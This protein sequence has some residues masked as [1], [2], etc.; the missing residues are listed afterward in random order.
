LKPTV[1]IQ[2]NDKQLVG[3]RV[4]VH[5]F[6][7]NSKSADR[8]D[9]RIM[10]QEEQPCFQAREG[11]AF[12]RGGTRRVW[13]NDDLQSFTPLRFLPPK[14]MEYRG[15]ALVVDPDVFAVGDAW[16][17]LDRDMNGKAIMAVARPGH[18][19]RPG[20]L[21]SSVMLLDCAR[22]T[23]WDMERDFDALFRFERDY[24]DW[25]DLALEPRDTIGLLEPEW[26][27]FDRL[28][29]STKLIHNT[30]RRT[31][32]WKTGLPVDFTV[33]DAKLGAHPASWVRFAKQRLLGTGGGGARYRPHPDP[34]Q[35]AFF[36]GLLRECV[37]RGTLTRDMLRREMARNHVRHDILDLI[38]RPR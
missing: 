14:L 23:H 27:H 25:I 12:L 11:Q 4:S 19:E 13:R 8:F 29:A 18:N 6:V 9:I 32:P 31:Q 36:V 28:D 5:S 24:V 21:A 16:E 34:R 10:R 15:R 35:E 38:D 2:T 7:R 17:L 20:Y 22:L 33:T 3:A 37:E 1:F 30:K 26:N